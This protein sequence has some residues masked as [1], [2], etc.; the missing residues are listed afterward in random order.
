MARHDRGATPPPPPIGG[1][2]FQVVRIVAAEGES[3]QA[4]A[5]HSGRLVPVCD[6][7]FVEASESA[8]PPSDPTPPT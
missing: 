3:R 2:E 6:R 5:K 7:E 8:T 4:I 1:Y